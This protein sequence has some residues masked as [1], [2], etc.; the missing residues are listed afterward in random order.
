MTS[1]A[2]ASL[3][4][5]A[6]TSLASAAHASLAARYEQPRYRVTLA[7]ETS[8]GRPRRSLQSLPARE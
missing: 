2:H 1:A 6:H 8:C 3:A 7:L 4:S 5:A